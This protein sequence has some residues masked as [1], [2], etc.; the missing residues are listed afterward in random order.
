METLFLRRT[1]FHLLQSRGSRNFLYFLSDALF[2]FICWA[3]ELSSFS[4]V[5]IFLLYFLFVLCS[6]MGY[7]PDIENNLIMK[8]RMTK[9]SPCVH[10]L[11]LHA[12]TYS[13]FTQYIAVIRNVSIESK[14]KL[15]YI[16]TNHWNVPR[17]V[18]IQWKLTVSISR[19][20][21]YLNLLNLHYIANL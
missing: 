14:K 15:K 19:L 6:F 7:I 16:S 20:I 10:K 17:M 11:S 13:W 1:W 2:M 4:C 18:E 9:Y 12:F 21:E 3:L 8:T 5:R